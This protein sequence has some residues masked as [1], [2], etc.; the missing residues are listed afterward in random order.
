[1]LWLSRSVTRHEVLEEGV[2]PNHG[3]C[4]RAETARLRAAAA[5]VLWLTVAVSVPSRGARP[6]QGH[7]QIFFSKSFPGS[8]PAYFE[9]TVDSKGKAF[10]REDAGEDPLEFTLRDDETREVFE[11]AERLGRFEKPLQSDLKVAF[12]GTKTLRYINATGD[13]KETQFT[14]S[15]DQNAQAIVKW[16]ENA[17]E[18]ARRRIEL[19][20]VVQFD[21]LGVNKALLLFQSS[22]DDGRVVAA[23]Q[24]LPILKTIAGQSKFMHMARARAASLVE[25]IEAGAP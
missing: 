25:R 1:M 19:E 18:T 8:I 14:Y 21:P 16:F 4:R 11:L 17:A 12:T 24:F 3:Q 22:F 10:Y 2:G 15:A 7:D 13:V 6:E 20:R 5:L 23:K 9:L